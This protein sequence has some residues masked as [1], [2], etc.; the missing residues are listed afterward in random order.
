MP[1]VHLGHNA[2][3]RKEKEVSHVDEA[4]RRQAPQV[5]GFTRR[6]IISS[7]RDT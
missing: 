6:P 4:A 7:D 2:G 1:L 3:K 5:E